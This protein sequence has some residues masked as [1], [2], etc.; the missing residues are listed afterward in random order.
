MSQ[1]IPLAPLYD[2]LTE[3]VPYEKFADFYEYI[4]KKYNISPSLVLDIACGTGTLT[5]ILAKRG[6]EMIG[7][8]G[9]QDMLAQ[10]ME[11]AFELPESIRPIFLCQEME[12]LDLY[13]TVEAAVCSLDGINYVPEENIDR[14]FERLHLFIEPGGVIIF[15]IN[16]PFKL[17]SLDG[18][19]FLDENEDVYCVW[20][21]VFYEEENACVYGMDLFS[22]KCG[23]MWERAQ[24][25]HVEY[26]HSTDMLTRHL[27]QH[28]FGEIS[29]FGEL[30]DRAPKI[31]ELRVF[32][33][34]KRM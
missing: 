13:G 4:F 26:A 30:E 27:E 16:T 11:K 1:Y 15:D 17:K 6:Y 19:V 24:E 34:A 32:V 8:D 21:S 14:V 29:I 23:D 7:A 33:A 25:E 3:D 9:S 22:H 20:R 10:A 28:G 18:Q 5:C 31:D 12:E 2:S